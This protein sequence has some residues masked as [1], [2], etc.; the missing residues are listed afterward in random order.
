[1]PLCLPQTSH[2]LPGREPGP[3]RL[4][5]SDGLMLSE[6]NS[7]AKVNGEIMQNIY[8]FYQVMKGML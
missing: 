4:E 7:E 5:A 8:E 2:A 1:V 3:P 6:M